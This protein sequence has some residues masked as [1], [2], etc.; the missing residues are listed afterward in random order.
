MDDTTVGTYADHSERT[1][2]PENSLRYAVSKGDIAVFRQGRY[3]QPTLLTKAA[4]DDWINAK[5]VASK[6][7]AARK[8]KLAT[9]R[10]ARRAKTRAA[11]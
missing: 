1:G 3:G 2:V 10:A 9:A 8:R 7:E 5:I 4:V 6:R 11:A